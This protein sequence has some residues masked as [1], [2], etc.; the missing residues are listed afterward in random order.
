[1]SLKQVHQHEII[2]LGSRRFRCAVQND[3]S[4]RMP[5]G[6]TWEDLA[7]LELQ[8]PEEGQEDDYNYDDESDSVDFSDSDSDEGGMVAYWLEDAKK[9]AE[10]QKEAAQKK[11]AVV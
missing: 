11:K 2:Q 7:R 9:A 10:T 6:L 5:S 3:K 4:T 1:M 8:A